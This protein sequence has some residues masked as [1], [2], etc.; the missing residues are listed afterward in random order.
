MPLDRTELRGK[1]AQQAALTRRNIA[2]HRSTSRR[3]RQ[4]ASEGVEQRIISEHS[5]AVRG[6][7]PKL[8]RP[9]SPL[10]MRLQANAHTNQTVPPLGHL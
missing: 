9:S 3:G 10:P 4:I 5:R 6:R 8:D 1:I 7:L 2:A